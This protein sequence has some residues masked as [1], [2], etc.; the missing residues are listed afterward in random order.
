M[1]LSEKFDDSQISLTC[2]QDP[3]TTGNFEITIDGKLVHSKKA[4]LGKCESD[5]ERSALVSAI[6]AAL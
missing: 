4:G 1:F 2:K 3:G 6:E 5:K